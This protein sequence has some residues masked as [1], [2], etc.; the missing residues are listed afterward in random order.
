[1]SLLDW[2]GLALLGGAGAL[3]RFLVDEVVTSRRRGVFPLGTL[4]VNVSGTFVLGLL[5]GAHVV[6]DG[7]FLAGTGLVGSY[8]TFSTL[9]FQTQRL[10][11]EGDAGM[12]GLNLVAS[13]AVGVAAGV[14]GWAL[15]AA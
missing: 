6:G 1:M 3:L 12:A 2:V 7:L 5:T 4:L 10:G 14:A 11:E 9:M 15:G 8:T 13:V